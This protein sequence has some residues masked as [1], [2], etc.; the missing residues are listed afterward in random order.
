MKIPRKMAL[1]MRLYDAAWHLLI[2]LLKLNPRLKEG[3]GS[4]S[5][6]DNLKPADIWIHA[7]S[8]GE[9]FLALSLIEN[10]NPARPVRVLITTNTRQGHDIINKGILSGDLDKRMPVECEYIPFDRPRLMDRAVLRVFPKLMI[11]LETEIWPGLLFA[12]KKNN[13]KTIIINGRLTPRSLNHYMLWPSLWKTLRPDHILAISAEDANRFATLFGPEKVQ[14]M[15]NI[16]FDRLKTTIHHTNN[17]LKKFI[18]DHSAFLVLGSVRRPEEDQVENIIR[19]V[20]SEMPETIIGL[21]PRHMQRIRHWTQTMDR[22]HIRS[23]L[24][25]ELNREPVSAGTVILWDVFGELNPAYA[26]AN[27]VFVGGSL[28]PLGG[29]NFLEPMIFGITPIIGPSWEN[30]AWVG[31]EIFSRGF[32]IQEGNWQSVASRLIR[33]LRRPQPAGNRQAAAVKYLEAK[34]GGT[35]QACNLILEILNNS[36]LIQENTK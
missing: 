7:A 36:H 2:P 21:F 8:A 3:Y 6:P 17:E 19:K 9:S 28:A 20:Q 10:L 30:F 18:P 23:K 15:P 26:L 32:V 4:R 22:L 1:A 11:L 14:E 5:R 35:A 27:A 16:K 24:R 31:D 13:I 25:S 12:L 29:Q 33:Q 34:K